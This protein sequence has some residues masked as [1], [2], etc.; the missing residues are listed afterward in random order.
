MKGGFVAALLAIGALDAARPGWLAGDL[1]LLSVIEAEATGNGTL[2]AGR[3]GVLAEAALLLVPTDLE[4]VLGGI[5]MVWVDVIVHGLAGRAG[6]ADQGINPILLAPV[7]LDALSAL[8]ESM[9]AAHAAGPG[10]GVRDDRAPVHGERGA[11]RVRALALQ[12]AGGRAASASASGTPGSGAATRPSSGSARRCGTPPRRHP[13]LARQPARGDRRPASGPSATRRTPTPRSSP[14][15]PRPTSTR[16]AAAALTAIGSTTDAR[17][18]VNRFG[19]PAAAYGPRVREH[20]RRGRGGRAR[21]R[22][23]RAATIAPA[24]AR[25]FDA[26]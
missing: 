3:A 22:R 16:T 15:S 6:A 23:R 25:R 8:E 21:E 12:R 2:A 18:Y 13:W 4:V 11:V 1:T 20:P 9:N 10:S 19:V 17:Y 5:A 24:A 26:A 7:V 14:R